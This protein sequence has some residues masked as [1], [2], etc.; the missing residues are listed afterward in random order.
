M[1]GLTAFTLLSSNLLISA[2]DDYHIP[3]VQESEDSTGEYDTPYESL[4]SPPARKP[5]PYTVFQTYEEQK[6]DP[7]IMPSFGEK[8]C[9]VSEAPYSS[10]GRKSLLSYFMEQCMEINML[11]TNNVDGICLNQGDDHEATEDYNISNFQSSQCDQ[12]N[13][14]SIIAATLMCLTENAVRLEFIHYYAPLA[15]HNVVEGYTLHRKMMEAFINIVTENNDDAIDR[16]PNLMALESFR[17]HGHV[18]YNPESPFNVDEENKITLHASLS[19][20]AAGVSNMV[21]EDKYI[22]SSGTTVASDTD[23]FAAITDDP[24][25]YWL[26]RIVRD[27]K[28]IIYVNDASTELYEYYLEGNGMAMFCAFHA[29][30]ANHGGDMD[31]T[32]FPKYDEN[33]YDGKYAPLLYRNYEACRKQNGVHD[34]EADLIQTFLSS[35]EDTSNWHYEEYNAIMRLYVNDDG[36][37]TSE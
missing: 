21:G 22:D 27:A 23:I 17:M 5:Y 16:Y 25:N 6:E 14:A 8:H 32:C 3:T 9:F 24:K 18:V 7:T 28:S 36:T 29:C 4:E 11:A 31:G 10:C 33:E 12:E 15:Q 37:C 2:A 1:K 19:R 26:R 20:R 13:F 30:K 35:M 34:N